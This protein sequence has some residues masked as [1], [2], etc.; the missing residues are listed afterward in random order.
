G[1]SRYTSVAAI[2]SRA[3]Q[4]AQ[5]PGATVISTPNSSSMTPPI[6]LPSRRRSSATG[7]SEPLGP[8]PTRLVPEPQQPVR[9]RVHEPRRAADEDTRPLARRPCDLAQEFVVD[10][11]RVAGPAIRLRPRQRLEDLDV[12]PDSLQLLAVDHVLERPRGIQQANRRPPPRR[13]DHRHQRHD[14]GAASDE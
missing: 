7:R 10:S 4:W 1:A 6:A 2:C 3:P 8:N 5:T 13:A 9:R 14:A 12:R 11:P